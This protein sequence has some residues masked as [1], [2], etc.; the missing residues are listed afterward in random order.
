MGTDC[1]KLSQWVHEIKK[2][3]HDD[4]LEIL[5]MDRSKDKLPASCVLERYDLVIFTRNRFLRELTD[6]NGADVS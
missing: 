1:Q 2:H 4:A 3:F 6:L 5:I